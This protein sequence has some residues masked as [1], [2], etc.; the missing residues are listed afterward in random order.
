MHWRLHARAHESMRECMHACTACLYLNRKLGA[1]SHA[2]IFINISKLLLSRAR[3]KLTCFNCVFEYFFGVFHTFFVFFLWLRFDFLV[4][5]RPF[6]V[7]IFHFLPSFVSR[8]CFLAFYSEWIG[9][10]KACVLCVCKVVSFRSMLENACQLFS[11]IWYPC[12][13]YFTVTPCVRQIFEIVSMGFTLF[14][15]CGLIITSRTACRTNSF[16]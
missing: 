5:Q 10:R 13:S 8:S 12:Y 1:S 14:F 6:A 3:H 7:L 16:L 11:S 15:R 4:R 9:F 2:T